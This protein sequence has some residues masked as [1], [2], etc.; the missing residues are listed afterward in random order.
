MQETNY[1]YANHKYL[2]KCWQAICAIINIENIF[3]IGTV[4]QNIFM[5]LTRTL[6]DRGG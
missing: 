4:P 5:S 3:T 2:A 1:K 6:K